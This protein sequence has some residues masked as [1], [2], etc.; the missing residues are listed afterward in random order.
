MSTQSE[1]DTPTV[2]A[3]TEAPEIQCSVSS[4]TPTEISIPENQEQCEE[5]Y[6]P[7]NNKPDVE[8]EIEEE[9]SG[10]FYHQGANAESVAEYMYKIRDD[11][12]KPRQFLGTDSEDGIEN[13]FTDRQ[14]HSLHEFI[15]GDD[16]L[17]PFIDFDL[18]QEKLNSIVPKL[19]RKETYYA[20]IGAFR[21]VCIE[22]Y[23]DWDIKTL[24]VANSSDQKKMSYHIST[25]GM[26]LKNI[27]ACA[28]FTELVRKKLPVGLQAEKIVDNIA[29][30][31]SFSLRMLGTP[32]IIKET[33]EHVRPKR[34]VIPE[35]GTIFDFMLRPPNDEAPVIESPLLSTPEPVVTRNSIIR[36]EVA[37][38]IEIELEVVAKLLEEYEIGGYELSCPREN[39]PDTFPLK[40][41]TPA[42]CPLCYREYGYKDPHTSDNAY[43]NRNKKSYSFYCHRANNNREAGSRKPSIKLTAKEKTSEQEDSLPVPV[44]LDRPRITDP[45]DHF[46]WGDL[47]DMCASGE[48]YT[49]NKVYEAIQATIACI[50]RGKK[51][52]LFKV[53]DEDEDG[54][55]TFEFVP[56]LELANYEIN[57]IEFGGESIKL[58]SLIDRAVTKG[59]IR[60]RKI[61]FL[62]YPPNVIP[63]KTNFFN[64]FLGFSAKPA[65]EINPEIMDP[66]LWHVNNIICNEDQNLNEYI[67]NWWSFLV[68]K[69]EKKPRSICVLKSTLQQCGKNIIVDFIGDKVLGP[70]LYYATSDLG[71]ILGKFNSL[72]QGKKLVVMNET[73]MSSGEWHRFNGHLKSLI[74]DPKV[75]I[76]RKGI[77][78]IHLKEYSAFMVTSNQDAPLKIDGGDARIV[79]FDVSARCRGNIP[80]FKRLAKILEHPDAPGVVMSYLLNRDLSNWN[81]QEIPS[82]KMKTDTIMKQ[83]PNP[84]RFIIQHINSWSENQVEELIC[85]NLYQDYLTWCGGEGEDRISNN[86]FGGFLPPIGIEKKQVRING[87]RERVYILDRSKIVAKLRESIGD[88]EEF[89]DSSQPETLA[90]TSTDIPV[91]GVPEIITPQPEKK[92]TE[93]LPTDRIKKGKAS[94]PVPP[95]TNTA[96]DLFDYI[97]NESSVPSLSKSTDISLPPEIVD[98]ELVDDKPEPSPK[99]VELVSDEPE[100]VI[101]DSPVLPVNNEPESSLKPSN[102]EPTTQ[103]ETLSPTYPAR[104]QREARLRQKAIE[105]GEDPDK[106]VTITEKD[107]LDSIAF[108]D[109][110]QTDARMCGHAK[111][112]DEDPKEYMLMEVRDRLIGEEIIRRYDEEHGIASSWLD[113]DEEWKKTV[114][115][116]QENGMLW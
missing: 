15:D 108:K 86:K 95:I 74:V 113:T 66:I 36:T 25:F 69:P 33:N 61:N 41:V 82:T 89:S 47:L 103:A 101:N 56:K 110:M 63:P 32:K 55:R 84:I 39:F 31:S 54:G 14:G 24:T 35:N 48:K 38:D 111:E 81:P 28:L 87:K 90:I 7:E 26:R 67:W 64:L 116:L 73:S 71:K 2:P 40:R 99:I 19:T 59:L 112:G 18:S 104:E 94:S 102:E 9:N 22:I 12:V 53:E 13:I 3:Y 23:S 60:Y 37:E 5:T 16:P 93:P 88:S 11:S 91:F 30:S 115:I 72:I 76:E 50:D 107:K 105:L 83:L 6:V 58:R 46:V 106:F 42:F 68:Q 97:T 114:N 92:I 45:N 109:K 78:P 96:Q 43:V 100:L 79:C 1:R 21:E 29:N 8:P 17:R 70:N 62:P 51:F 44:K 27:T 57:I 75:S 77:E 49:R 65:N 4:D 85:G 52:W 98:V 10:A 80:Y 34:A 20:L